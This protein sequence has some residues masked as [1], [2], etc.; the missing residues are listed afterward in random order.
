MKLKYV[1]FLPPNLNTCRDC[2]NEKA[3]MRKTA[4]SSFGKGIHW[5]EDNGLFRSLFGKKVE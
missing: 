4:E 1:E 2:K 3:R 5:K